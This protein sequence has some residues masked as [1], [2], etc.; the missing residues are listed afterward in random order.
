MGQTT[1]RDGFHPTPPTR[2]RPRPHHPPRS[3]GRRPENP[4]GD[5]LVG[6][7]GRGISENA[8][9]ILGGGSGGS[10]GI[11]RERERD[12]GVRL[13]LGGRYGAIHSS[14]GL[15]GVYGGGSGSGG[16][17]GGGLGRDC[18][19][20]VYSP[21]VQKS[22]IMANAVFLKKASLKL[23]KC[24]RDEKVLLLEFEFNAIVNGWITVYYVARRCDG[25]NGGGDGFELC[26]K[27]KV[28]FVGKVDR[29]PKK[30]RFVADGKSQRYVQ[31]FE[32]G[33]DLRKYDHGD[34]VW[35]K[36]S[37]WFPIVIRLEADYPED[38]EVPVDKR[39]KSQSS[40]ITLVPDWRVSGGYGLKLLQQQ[41]VV[42][43]NIYEMKEMYGIARSSTPA[44]VDGDEDGVEGSSRRRGGG[45]R[46]NCVDDREVATTGS[47]CVICL[48]ERS[49]T[50]IRPCNHLCLCSD[51]AKHLFTRSRRCP[52]CREQAKGLLRI[53]NLTGGDD[54]WQDGRKNNRDKDNDRDGAGEGDRGSRHAERREKKKTRQ[55]DSSTGSSESGTV[56]GTT[57]ESGQRAGTS[58]QASTRA[59]SHFAPRDAII[60]PLITT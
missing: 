56:V 11:M 25:G 14:G 34:L 47:E 43:R 48:T 13:G 35:R 3:L 15:Y 28:S 29:K 60:V 22:A 40:F 17:G 51:C 45:S 16:S 9:D 12:V 30:T 50:A 44:V 41:I 4:G 58:Y 39:L 31:K 36:G 7:G 26:E 33:L 2:P 20:G 32:K 10:S 37:K 27:G 42:D 55:Q 46:G 1:S 6:P 49:D 38:Y 52:I 21:P 8:D 54:V 23:R 59:A 18:G 5:A 24:E 53:T 19:H 57:S